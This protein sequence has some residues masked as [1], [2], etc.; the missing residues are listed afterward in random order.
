MINFGSLH[1]SSIKK[2]KMFSYKIHFILDPVTFL[3]LL[4]NLLKE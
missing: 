4:M 2:K 1:M 3:D